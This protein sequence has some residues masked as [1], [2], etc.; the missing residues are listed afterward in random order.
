[1]TCEENTHA[2]EVSARCQIRPKDKVSGHGAAK[3]APE[4]VS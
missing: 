2:G 3:D 1:M 4:G